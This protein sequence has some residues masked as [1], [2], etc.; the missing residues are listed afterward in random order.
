[1]VNPHQ[2]DHWVGM[3]CN[4]CEYA[5]LSPDTMEGVK[6]LMVLHLRTAHPEARWVDSRGRV[7]GG[8]QG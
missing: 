5:M 2:S 4:L 3:A 8:E 7:F 1:V 6:E